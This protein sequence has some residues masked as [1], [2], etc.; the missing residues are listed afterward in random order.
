MRSKFKWIF[1]LLVALTVQLSFAQEKT[2]TGVVSDATGTLPGANVIVKGTT[3]GTQTDID[4][5]YTITANVGETLLF[6]FVGMNDREIKV[7]AANVINVVLEQGVILNEVVVEGYRTTSKARTVVAQTTVTSKTIENRPNA[8]FVQT[9]QGQV[10]GLNISTGTG[11][12][13]AKSTVL[14]RGLGSYNASSDPLYVI[15]GMPTNGD[16]FRSLNPEDIETLTVLKDAAAKSIYGNRGSNGVIVI[17]TRRAAFDEAKM[18]VRYSFRTGFTTLQRT[19]YNFV[20]ARE[21]LTLERDLGVGRGA[22]NPATNAPFTDEEIAAYST[23]TDWVD[24]FF[25][26][27][28]TAD[29]QLSFE[30][31]GKNMS[32]YTSLGYTDQQGILQSTNLKRFSFRNNLSIK[33]PDNKFTYDHSLSIAYSKNNEA[34]SLGT[35][36]INQNYVLGATLGAPY[37]APSEYENSQQLFELYQSDGTLRYTPLFLIDKLATFENQTD[38]ARLL[39]SIEGSYRIFDDFTLRSRT[40]VDYVST[41]LVRSQAPLS[42]ND[43]VFTVNAPYEG[44][45]ESMS[46]RYEF[47]FSQLWQAG[48]ERTFA[49]KHT[50][51]ALLNA[52]YNFSQVNTNTQ[53]QNGLDPDAWVPGTGYGYMQDVPEHDLYVPTISASKIKLN[54]ISYFAT[55]DYD[56]DGKYGIVGSVRRDGTSRF[57]K[58]NQWGTFWS[59]GARWNIDEEDFLKENSFIQSLKLRAS[60]GTTGNQRIASG[61]E[62]SGIQP[63][64]FVDT[65]SFTSAVYSGQTGAIL[66]LGDDRLHW[67][68]TT[69]ANVGLDWEVYNS[70]FRGSLDLYQRTTKDL[71]FTQAASPIVGST[72]VLISSTTEI[73]NRG[74]ELGFA[75][76]LFKNDNLKVTLRGN[77]S[78]NKNEISNITTDAESGNITS[79]NGGKVYEFYLIPYA[80]VNPDTGNLL[81]VA[82]DGTLTETPNPDVDRRAT[83]KNDIPEYQGGFGFDVDYKGFFVTTNFT[84]QA[85]AHRIDFDLNGLYDPSSLDNGF[86][87]SRDLFDAWQA[88]GDITDVPSLTASNLGTATN[89]SDRFL[90]DASFIRLRYAQ[91]GYRVPTKYL[92][93]TFLTGVTFY[94]Q[95]ENLYTWSKWKGFDAESDRASDQGQYPTP[96]IVSFGVDIRF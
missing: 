44:S 55:L 15:D 14:V 22:N 41:R 62:F 9:L 42:F 25:R 92:D 39:G 32:S 88:P 61:T 10:A 52:E 16:N 66:T 17:T 93:K 38:E 24:Y 7:G 59:V 91:I 29:H 79:R 68:P 12:P 23:N 6:S 90:V 78:Y 60:Y 43:L 89:D 28:V 67:E 54:M 33:S 74:I 13:G 47:R 11:Q 27:G 46:S 69:E 35:G 64:A 72:G 83:G 26:T 81:F 87:V 5:K 56:Y 21:M 49:E 19:K 84:Y 58:D 3:R 53:V 36:G 8:S 86:V 95:G 31:S 37:I 4:G 94:A 96:R 48:W 1:T 65:Y 20:N 18:N 2:V 77:W 40:G 71:F 80:G 70:R 63:P 76:D 85:K 34:T 45:F 51:Q 73:D 75:Y 50:V 30:N 57:N 82:A